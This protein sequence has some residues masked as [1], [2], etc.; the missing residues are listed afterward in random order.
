MKIAIITSSF[1]PVIDGVTIAVFNRVKQL[2]NLGHRVKLFCPDYSVIEHIYPNWQEYTGE[3]FAGVT[4]INLPSTESIGLDFERDVTSKSYKIVERELAAFEPDIIHVDE[5]ERL[6]TRFLKIPGV[7]FAKKNDIACVAFFHTNYLEYLDDYFQLPLGLNQLLKKILQKLFLK[8]YNRYDLT[9]TA[10]EITRQKLLAMKF[11]KVRFAEL[12]GLDLEKF[13]STCKEL[14]FFDQTLNLPQIDRQIKLIFIGRLTPD[15]GWDF[16]LNALADL[17]PEIIARLALIII[18]IGPMQ[19]E[20]KISL[21]KLMP[22]VYLLGRILPSKIPALLINSDIFVTNSE[23][24]TR[25]LAVMEA[26]AA[27][28]PAIAPRAGGIIDTIED[29]ETGLLYQPQDKKDFLAKLTLLINDS[30][31]RNSLG[32]NARERSID[33]SWQQ[34]TANLVNIW[35]EV[36][37]NR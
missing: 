10:S 36:I 28:I 2:S 26:L 14:D 25:G 29:G 33:Y 5:P 9:L 35:S 11:K 16:A 1:F 21:G 15:K 24:E 34:V 18:G 20:I 22:H 8:I 12:L 13:S 31:L 23:K 19:E 6:A 4:V 17:K 27:G 32:S 37:N 30:D 3:I 7:K